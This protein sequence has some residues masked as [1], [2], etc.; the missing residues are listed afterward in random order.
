MEYAQLVIVAILIEAIWENLKMIWKDR[1]V[2]IN[3]VGVLVLSIIVC[4]L[5][6]IDIFPIVGLS[7]SVPFVGSGL[8]GIIVSRG[9]NFVNDLFEKLKVK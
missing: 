6:K 3:T 7:L 5:T 9:A 2:N 8:T 4:I 1:K